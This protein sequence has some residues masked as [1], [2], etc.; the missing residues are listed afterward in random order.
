MSLTHFY[1]PCTFIGLGSRQALLDLKETVVI[2]GHVMRKF[3]GPVLKKF[4]SIFLKLF[5]ADREF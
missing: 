1:L 3:Q 5:Q 4:H 2:F